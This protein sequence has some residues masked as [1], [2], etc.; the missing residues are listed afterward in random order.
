M[1][2]YGSPI[3]YYAPNSIRPGGD[4]VSTQAAKDLLSAPVNQLPDKSDIL[5]DSFHFAG[6]KVPSIDVGSPIAALRVLESIGYLTSLFQQT[7]SPITIN[8]EKKS[9]SGGVQTDILKGIKN[10][11]QTLNTTVSNL[12]QI[13]A[14]NT[15]SAQSSKPESVTLTAGQESPIISASVVPKRVAS[16]NVL[17]SNA[18]SFPYPALGLTGS[19]VVNG[20]NVSV[21]SADTIITIKD[22]INYG[23]DYNHN[24]IQDGPQDIDGTGQT[25]VIFIHP[26]RYTPGVY[27]VK[28]NEGKGS[29]YP[30]E[31]VNNTGLI[32]GGSKQNKVVAAIESNRLKLT[33]VAGGSTT[34]D[35]QD[36]D[37]VLLALGFFELNSKGRPIQ[38]EAQYS[39]SVNL[40]VSPKKAVIKVDGET[41]TNDTNVFTG[42]VSDSEITVKKVS[43]TP[44]QV[45]TS[46][47]PANAASR[48]KV[49]FNNFN[50]AIR[51][52]NGAM[53]ASKAFETDSDIQRI[54]NAL[55][56]SQEKIPAVTKRNEGIDAVRAK[57][58]NQGMI[59][60]ELQ[61]TKKNTLQETAVTSFVQS[62]KDQVMMPFTSAPVDLYK[63]LSSI[64]IR[65]KDDNTFAVNESDLK[66]ALTVNTKEVLSLFTDPGTGILPQ[67]KSQL[68]DI[69]AKG[70]GRIDYKETKIETLAGIPVVLSQDFQKFVEGSTEQKK[71]QT[72]IAVA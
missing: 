67:L 57:H 1:Q 72:L 38:K 21:V 28:D 62:I 4:A 11:F 7:Q 46:L 47:D 44:A 31:D 14:L 19:F 35:L 27:I 23:S 45:S 8:L 51:K 41:V 15:R 39:G 30:S 42:V 33:S 26:G 34:I 70:I 10:S 60:F 12:L 22:K 49:L 2:V 50:D 64:G 25:G 48:I 16:N 68:S 5:R 40:I 53:L 65:T 32:V 54:R 61:N 13:D 71:A 59:G 43:T 6:Q 29:L 58:E 37:N 3:T 63:R 55:T 69:L 24:G 20:Y 17:V 56:Q 36:P 52:I 18:Q 9:L 66:R